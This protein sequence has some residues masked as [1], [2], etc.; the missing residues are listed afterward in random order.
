MYRGGKS[1]GQIS[2][3][4]D[5]PIDTVRVYIKCANERYDQSEE[6]VDCGGVCPVQCSV[7]YIWIVVSAAGAGILGFLLVM[8]FRLRR[9][10][11][12]LTWE[13]L[14]NRWA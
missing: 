1:A 10:G 7:D 2:T 12:E 4:L 8:Y 14:K 9:E 11:R 13:E 3:S 6:A 5:I